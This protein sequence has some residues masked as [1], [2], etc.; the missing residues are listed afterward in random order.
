MGDTNAILIFFCFLCCAFQTDKNGCATF[1]FK[2]STVPQPNFPQIFS[3]F[4]LLPEDNLV[5][6]AKVTEDGTGMGFFQLFLETVYFVLRRLHTVLTGSLFL[7]GIS[8]LQGKAVKISY[9]I[10]KLSFIDTPKIYDQ[11]SVV[12]GKV[13]AKQ[14]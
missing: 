11:G 5:L 6:S 14:L 4:Y 13:S 10:G 3:R 9:V 1:I 7:T 2:M 8:H 12:E